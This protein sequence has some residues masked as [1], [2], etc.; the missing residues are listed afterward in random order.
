M[1]T[2]TDIKRLQNQDDIETRRIQN[3]E[4]ACKGS[5]EDWPKNFW[6]G[7][8]KKLCKKYNKMDYFK[9]SIN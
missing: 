4:E 3:A 6:Y 5:K 8:F 7:V 2:E 9:K 1:L